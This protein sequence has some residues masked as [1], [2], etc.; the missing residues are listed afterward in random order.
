MSL[1]ISRRG[2]F[3]SF[4]AVCS[5]F[6]LGWAGGAGAQPVIPVAPG[7]VLAQFEGLVDERGHSGGAVN[8]SLVKL[9]T[10]TDSNGAVLGDGSVCPQA[11]RLSPSGVTLVCPHD[12]AL[13]EWY[14]K[15]LAG[16]TDRKSGSVIYLDRA[17]AEVLRQYNLFECWPVSV[18]R[19]DGGDCD[20]TDPGVELM[21]VSLA[22]KAIQIVPKPTLSTK[23][24]KQGHYAVSNF[25]IEVDGQSGGYLDSV[26]G[27]EVSLN[28]ASLTRGEQP[29]S[30]KMA[31]GFSV[32]LGPDDDCDGTCDLVLQSQGKPSPPL[33][34]KAT[35]N[36][37]RSNIKHGKAVELPPTVFDIQ[38][39]QI[40]SVALPT[41][42][43]VPKPPAG[44]GASL[45]T[46]EIRVD[47][48][49]MK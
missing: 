6:V 20:D 39:A 42:Q 14:K 33:N 4:F 27:M 31:T 47:R 34:L 1:A 46:L 21:E 17:G 30:L 7:Q 22:T 2:T 45:E 16:Q 24:I 48:I 35:I 43:V 25:H 36:T 23:S 9:G 41:F 12:P 44:G 8:L 49:E 32:L 10:L 38:G 40:K 28:A 18:T 37:T 19:Y 29:G 3:I 15:V 26:S 11:S 5:A 13:L